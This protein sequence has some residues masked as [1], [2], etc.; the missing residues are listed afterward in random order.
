[1]PEI[2]KGVPSQVLEPQRKENN[3][4][5]PRTNADTGEGGKPPEPPDA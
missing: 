1:M 3:N 5:V 4:T 2:Q